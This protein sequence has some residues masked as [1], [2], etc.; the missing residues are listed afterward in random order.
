MIRH[1]VEGIVSSLLLLVLLLIICC[2][3]LQVAH[4]FHLFFLHCSGDYELLIKAFVNRSTI[5]SPPMI[6]S[7]QP[8]LMKPVSL[9]VEYEKNAKAIV[10]EILTGTY[11]INAI[12][13]RR[14]LS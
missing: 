12:K 1:F 13:S 11:T 2:T 8:D 4:T 14:L 7:I 5:L 3:Q 10:G 9:D 6:I